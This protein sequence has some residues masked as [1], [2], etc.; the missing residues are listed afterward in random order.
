MNPDHYVYAGFVYSKDGME[1]ITNDPKTLLFVGGEKI[2]N[3]M[4]YRSHSEVDL[5]ELQ[6]INAL[7]DEKKPLD[8]ESIDTETILSTF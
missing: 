5:F 1:I 2:M 7:L 3:G 4:L 6:R 8:K